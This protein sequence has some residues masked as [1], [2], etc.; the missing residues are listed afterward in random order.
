MFL[1][2]LA[3][4]NL[5]KEELT[6]NLL[7]LSKVELILVSSIPHSPPSLCSTIYDDTQVE[8]GVHLSCSV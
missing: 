2:V 7:C 8:C 3:S 6:D 4:K 5:C 1:S